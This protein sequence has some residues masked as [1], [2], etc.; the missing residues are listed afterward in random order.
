MMSD[1]IEFKAPEFSKGAVNMCGAIIASGL[2]S[3]DIL[4]LARA[5]GDDVVAWKKYIKECEKDYNGFNDWKLVTKR[6]ITSVCKTLKTKG[7]VKEFD[8][9]F[10]LL[11]YF[12]KNFQSEIN[13]IHVNSAGET[14][15][16]Y[17]FHKATGISYHGADLAIPYN[18]HY[19]RRVKGIPEAYNASVR[20]FM[21]EVLPLSQ[22]AEI[23]SDVYGVPNSRGG[24]LP[25]YN[26]GSFITWRN[27][28]LLKEA[29][30]GLAPYVNNLVTFLL[31]PLG[32]VDI[33]SH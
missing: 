27:L 16:D 11:N 4:L 22:C 7:L 12:L 30:E 8:E 3:Q 19:D 17:W 26:H 15:Q 6:N 20:T 23:I 13:V 32:E 28:D 24:S 25:W 21:A 18:N 10:F 14:I 1:E 2:T 29:K 31:M 5:C 9:S 33:I